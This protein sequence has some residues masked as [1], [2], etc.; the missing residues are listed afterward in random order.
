MKI[1]WHHSQ[2]ARIYK[3]TKWQCKA[4]QKEQA[5]FP[6]AA[7]KVECKYNILHKDKNCHL[8]WRGSCCNL[9]LQMIFYSES[10]VSG[11]VPEA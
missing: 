1:S 2:Q 6:Q 8:L 9:M 5:C 7:W 4:L 3:G 10:H 11:F